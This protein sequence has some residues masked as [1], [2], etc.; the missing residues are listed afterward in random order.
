M[1]DTCKKCGSPLNE[2][3]QTIDTE[4]C[5]RCWEL[6]FDEY[7]IEA[8]TPQE[9]KEWGRK[10]H[11]KSVWARKEFNE[12]DQKRTTSTNQFLGF[13]IKKTKRRL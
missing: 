7:M 11:I 6:E 5:D 13:R 3:N 1:V 10:P 12:I 4:M 2:Y 9:D 8:H